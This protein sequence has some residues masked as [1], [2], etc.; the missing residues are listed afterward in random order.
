MLVK[1]SRP[2]KSYPFNVI[3]L[4]KS[5]SEQ[6]VKEKVYLIIEAYGVLVH[7][8]CQYQKKISPPNGKVKDDF[9]PIRV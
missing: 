2:F 5:F 3:S 6:L 9:I 7:N 4:S 1:Y 8:G